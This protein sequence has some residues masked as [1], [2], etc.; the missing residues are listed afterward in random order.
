MDWIKEGETYTATIVFSSVGTGDRVHL[1]GVTL[2]PDIPDEAIDAGQI[3][4]SYKLTSFL[5]AKLRQEA[6]EVEELD[7]ELFDILDNPTVH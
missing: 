7:D 3:P 2:S 4:W 6:V 1:E 5:L